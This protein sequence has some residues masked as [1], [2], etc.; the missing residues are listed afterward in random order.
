MTV[1]DDRE[2]SG[3]HMSETDT[4][5]RNL[6]GELACHQVTQADLADELGMSEATVSE[7]LQGKGAFDTDQLSKI[8]DMFD[9]SLYQLM[10]KLLQ[11]IDNIKQIKP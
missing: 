1:T 8:A 11:P 3:N 6:S 4:I 10:L 5:A 9:M 2:R 7:R